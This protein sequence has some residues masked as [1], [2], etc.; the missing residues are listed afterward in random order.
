MDARGMP[1]R[2]RPIP[3][4]RILRCEIARSLR[5][6]L[7]R[8]KMTPDRKMT[9]GFETLCSCRRPYMADG[10]MSYDGA[11]LVEGLIA[12]VQRGESPYVKAPC[13]D[14]GMVGFQV[15]ETWVVSVCEP[16]SCSC[17][18]HK[19]GEGGSQDNCQ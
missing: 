11:N 8:S 12:Q 6:Q 14:E 18:S 15:R 13:G 4:L 5:H 2:M 9:P 7:L 10:V 1:S 17:C 3:K 19:E 16:V